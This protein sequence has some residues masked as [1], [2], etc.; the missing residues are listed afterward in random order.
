MIMR[1][2]CLLLFL[3]F[4]CSTWGQSYG[5]Q[6]E[7][8]AQDL[9]T[10]ITTTDTVDLE[11]YS[12]YRVYV[13]TALA[14]DK[15]VSITGEG[16]LPGDLSTTT[17]FYQSSVGG[18]TPGFTPPALLAAFPDL[19]YD[20]W[21][22]IGIDA[23]ANAQNGEQDILLLE[24][25]NSPWGATFE[26]EGGSLTFGGPIGGGWI[27]QPEA[28]NA[29]AGPDRKVLIGQFTTDG[30]LSGT[31]LVQVLRQGVTSNID[32]NAELRLYLPLAE[33]I[34]VQEPVSGPSFCGEGTVW[35]PAVGRCEESCA[36][37]VDGDGVVTIID[38]L[39]VLSA[40]EFI[41]P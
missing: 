6:V 38:I 17:Q 41:C 19:A 5:L 39:A 14:S 7:R 10:F 15:V 37:D 2:P 3:M 30:V 34:E 25:P 40:F 11:G 33:A 26:E 20:S 29:T 27:L 4:G 9:G 36:Q 13:T 35:N 28:T 12:T 18:L 24:A 8:V 23:P 21:I 31:L 32:A 16:D 22:S 1:V